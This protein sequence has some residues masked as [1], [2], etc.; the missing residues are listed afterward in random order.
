[1][2]AEIWS[3][4]YNIAC[5]CSEPGVQSCKFI[6]SFEQCSCKRKISI[7]QSNP[8]KQV[9]LDEKEEE[10]VDDIIKKKDTKTW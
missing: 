3:N 7:V 10:I 1:M 5:A 4:Y 9:F 6:A 8:Q 2:A